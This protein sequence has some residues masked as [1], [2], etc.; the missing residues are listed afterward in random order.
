MT[1][2]IPLE[3]DLNVIA[4]VKEATNERYVFLFDD[5]HAR[6]TLRT[7]GRFASNPELSFSWYD[8]AKLSRQVRDR[9]DP[10]T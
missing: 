5:D 2:R 1:N 6:D 8:A 4:L 7:L 9:C 3:Y 10:A